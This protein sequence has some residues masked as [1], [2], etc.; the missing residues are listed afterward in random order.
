MPE[1]TLDGFLDG[2]LQ[3]RQPRFGYRAATDPVFLAAAVDAQAGQRVLELGCGV[4]VA[5]LCLGARVADLTLVGVEV[6]AEYGAMA[7]GNSVQNGVDLQVFDC[8]LR[9]MPA[10]LKVQP[11][12]HVI[13]NPP[14]F[15]TG[16]VSAPRDVGKNTAHVGGE[17][18]ADWIDV[19]LRRM[20]SG[21]VMTLIHLTEQ[22]PQTLA[23]FSG[24]AGDVT[25]LPLASR[26]GKAAKRVLV[27]G[28]KGAKG[29][30]R[31]LAPFHVHSGTAHQQGIADYSPA[32]SAILR[33]G[34]AL[35]WGDS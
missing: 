29:A 5:S 13:A 20:Q 21:G 22:L 12:D 8:D 7:R 27:R 11:F 6:Q 1:T 18:M 26:P 34:A 19:G 4:G 28:R 31:L 3:V 32:S 16:S 35:D 15:T 2:R 10:E 23:A 33:D 24:R 9:Q 14:F 25:V 30:F 17:G